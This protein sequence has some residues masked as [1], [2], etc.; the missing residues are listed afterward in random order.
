MASQLILVLLLCAATA[1]V[2]SGGTVLNDLQ[3]LAKFIAK[4]GEENAFDLPPVTGNNNGSLRPVT[5][6]YGL[7]LFQIEE[8]KPNNQD[9]TDAVFHLWERQV[10]DDFR[11]KWDPEEFSVFST[12]TSSNSVW[13][14]DLVVEEAFEFSRKDVQT[15]VYSTGTVLYIPPIKMKLRCYR[16]DNGDYN[17]PFTAHSW[18]WDGFHVALDNYENKQEIDLFDFIELPGA[19]VV[20]TAAELQTTYY[21]CCPEPYPRMQFNITLREN[22]DEIPTEISLDGLK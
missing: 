15:V 22:W 6:Q 2:F 1:S 14:P 10:W 19:S 13:R 12:R 20:G 16:Q 11:L 21:P 3:K 7:A 17:C 9:Y 8:F 4:A 5:V 18:V